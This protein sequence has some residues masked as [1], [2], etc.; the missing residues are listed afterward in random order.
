MNALHRDTACFGRDEQIGRGPQLGEDG[1]L[2][3]HD[4]RDEKVDAKSKERISIS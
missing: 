2:I 4:T 3:R 1:E